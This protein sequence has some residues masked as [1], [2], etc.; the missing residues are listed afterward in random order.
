M[1]NSKWLQRLESNQLFLG[2]EPSE[3]TVSLICN[4]YKVLVIN[5]VSTKLAPEGLQVLYT[6]NF[7]VS[8]TGFEPML[9]P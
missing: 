5:G 4:I 7:L 2:Y 8:G 3:I 1:E 9:R 6:Y